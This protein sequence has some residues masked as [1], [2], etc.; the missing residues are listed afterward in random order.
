[1]IL[2]FDNNIAQLRDAFWTIVT[3]AGP[4]LIA[5]LLIGLI[6]GILQ[7]ATSINEMTLSFVPK[8]LL[9]LIFMAIF[10]AFMMTNLTEYFLRIFEEISNIR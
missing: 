4:V 1:M 10:A 9:V 8:I 7:A 3:I 2:E 5:A 6:I